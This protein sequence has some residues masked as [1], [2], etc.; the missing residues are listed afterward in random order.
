M[1]AIISREDAI[2]YLCKYKVDNFILMKDDERLE[3]DPSNIIAIEYMCDYELNLRAVLKVSLR[4]DV[5]KRLWIL[6]NKRD[7]VAKF[8]LSKIGMD[9]TVEEYLLDPE[10]VWNLEFGI[11]LNDDDESMDAGVIEDRLEENEDGEYEMNE[12]EEEN[13]FESETT[14]DIYLF[15]PKLLNASRRIYNDVETK[16]TLQQLTGRILTETK[17]A[18][19]LISRIENDEIYKELLVPALEAYKAIYYLDQYYGLYKFGAMIFYD[20][21]CMYILNTNGKVTAKRKDEWPETTILVNALDSATPGDGM[22]RLEEEE[23]FYVSISEANLSIQKPSIANNVTIGSEAKVVITDDTTIDIQEAD[24]SYVD[25]R[26]ETILYR[27]K[28]D[29]KYSSTIV[30]ARMEE[31]ESIIYISANNL[32]VNAFTPNK[33]YHLVFDETSKQEKYGK[34]RYRLAYKYTMIKAEGELFMNSSHI[35]VL[36]RCAEIS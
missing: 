28:G 8:E 6:R 31:N 21:D 12:L 3:T 2:A 17:H 34:Y 20:I 26:N 9:H 24:Q 22:V 25:Q 5:R 7:I 30:R 33:A 4:I 1:S 35:I 29:N 23:M 32:D 36:K 15:H 14:I 16:D 27:R 13:Y 10:E 19:V 18:D 11:Y